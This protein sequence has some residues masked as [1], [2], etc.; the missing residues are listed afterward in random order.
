MNVKVPKSWDSLPNKEKKKI[1]DYCKQICLESY[2]NDIAL[3]LDT[4]IKMACIILHDHFGF[5]EH[6]LMRFVGA[7]RM[8]F[9]MNFKWVRE[10]RQDAELNKKLA[11]IFRKYGYPKAAFDDIAGR[12]NPDD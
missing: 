11:K 5:G 2:N 3:V 12:L 10:K 6:R 7:H 1:E 4:Y 8:A 9:R